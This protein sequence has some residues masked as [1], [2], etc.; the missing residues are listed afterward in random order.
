MSW[1]QRLMW[2][3]FFIGL[4]AVLLRWHGMRLGGPHELLSYQASLSASLERRVDRLATARSIEHPRQ[5]IDLALELTSQSL[6]F[7]PEFDEL[8]EFDVSER[9]ANQAA[10]SQLFSAIFNRIAEG[11]SIKARAWVVQSKSPRVFGLPIPHAAFK[12]HDWVIVQPTE[13]TAAESWFVDP[14][15]HDALLGWNIEGNVTGLIPLGNSSGGERSKPEVPDHGIEDYDFDD[16]EDFLDEKAPSASA[17]S[18]MKSKT[19][20]A[21]ATT[22]AVIQKTKE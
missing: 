10:Y 2:S 12:Q 19:G 7:S 21:K 5:G 11:R 4:F 13:G 6:R 8:W 16:S 17:S 18:R 1:R 14:T 9:A 15:L 3:V 22:P 20:K